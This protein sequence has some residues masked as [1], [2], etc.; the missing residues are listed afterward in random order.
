MA[1]NL[2]Q[3]EKIVVKEQV[4][5]YCAKLVDLFFTNMDTDELPARVFLLKEI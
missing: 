4:C 1:G 5:I 3:E 2:N